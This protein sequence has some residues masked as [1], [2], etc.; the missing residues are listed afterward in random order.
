ME[1]IEQVKELTLRGYSQA[2]IGKELNVS[3]GVAQALQAKLIVE[4]K[5]H[6]IPVKKYPFHKMKEVENRLFE[7][8]EKRN[9]TFEEIDEQRNLEYV[10]TKNSCL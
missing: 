6:E 9:K 2:A 5:W 1:T 7:L 4:S 10:Y 3:Q 8:I